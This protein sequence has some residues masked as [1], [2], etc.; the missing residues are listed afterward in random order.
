MFL[1]FVFLG[2]LVPCTVM[3]QSRSAQLLAVA[4]AHIAGQQLDSADDELTE[5]LE[6]A[7]YIMDSSWTYVWRGVLEYQLGISPEG[8]MAIGVADEPAAPDAR[9][10]C[11][12]LGR[13]RAFATYAFAS[14]TSGRS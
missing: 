13:H 7:P 14:A 9:A 4:R 11:L 12:A 6:R 8:M 1:R 5:A 3:G 2:A 10:A